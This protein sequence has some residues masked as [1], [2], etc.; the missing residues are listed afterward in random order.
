MNRE[1]TFWV[2]TELFFPEETSTAYI[3]TKISQQVAGKRKVHVLCGPAAYQQSNIIAE[4]EQLENIQITRVKAGG[5]NKDKLLQRTWRLITIS[6]RLA[7]ALFR[8]AKKGDD[9]LLVTNPAPLLLLA[10]RI[11]RWKGLKSYTIVHDV[12]PENLVVAKLIKP[13][14]LSYRILRSIFNAAYSR[15]SILLVLGRDMKALFEE[16]LADY[17]KRPDIH[18]I[19][20]WADIE[21]VSPELKTGNALV[22]GLKISDKII[23]Q[24]AGNL[25]RVQGLQELFAIIKEVDNPLLHFMFIGEGACK[26]ELQGYIQQHQLHHVT[27][28][29]SFPRSKQQD[30]LNAAD[31]GIVSLQDGMVGLGVP[32]KSY[33]ILA[34]GKPILYI[35]DR[36][37]EIGQ[38]VE[39]H[40][41]GWCFRLTE[42]EALLSFFNSFSHAS[43][44]DLEMKGHRARSL[45]VNVYSKE[46]ILNRYTQILT[47][48]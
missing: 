44:A 13:A 40:E 26:K 1:K 4:N 17:R 35:G 16:K 21:I 45:A 15:M 32:S 22:Q 25:G 38:M 36:T 42:R 3:M 34:A 31:V 39:E 8:K 20:N 24:F 43:L 2:V 7:V 10:A 23:F 41:V 27:I 11:C 6:L 47:V 14:S 19:E 5:L 30:F 37:G 48:T 29:D 33:N 18:I 12:F 46:R 28:L 9:V